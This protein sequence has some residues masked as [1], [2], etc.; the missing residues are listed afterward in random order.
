MVNKVILASKSEVRNQILKQNNIICD[1][2]PS[3]LDE[4]LVKQSL[5][6]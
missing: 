4:D 2:V 1:V 5:R 6:K 3:N